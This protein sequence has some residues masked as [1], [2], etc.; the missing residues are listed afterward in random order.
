VTA[1]YDA[2]LLFAYGLNSTIE[3]MGDDVLM[4]PLNST[5]LATKMWGKSFQGI[6]G[7]VTIDKN[8]DRLSDYSLLDMNPVTGQFEIVANYLHNAVGLEFV[9]GKKIHWPGDRDHPPE[10]HPKC[11]FDNSLCPD[12]SSEAFKWLSGFLS[13]CVLILIVAVFLG[14]RHFKLEA[15]ISSMTWKINPND[16]L[17]CNSTNQ[18]RNSFHTRMGSTTSIISEDLISL[19]GEQQC[20]ITR[21][22]YKGNHVA[23]KPIDTTGINLNRSLM[24][25]LKRMKALQHDHLAR[26]YG[27]AIDGDPTCILT[28]Y[29]PRGSLED[30]LEDE[31]I[32]LERMFQ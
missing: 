27:A 22:L 24:L 2:M 12:D 20:F 28:E 5:R 26:F 17:L 18:A 30:I 11:G 21:G 1:F 6:T 14:Y 15:E 10:D 29:C 9:D 31:R 25:E 16:I 4:Q 3:E 19:A 13:I 32:K 7:N 23:I 8:G